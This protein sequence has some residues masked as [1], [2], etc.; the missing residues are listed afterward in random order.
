M[1]TMSNQQPK[2]QADEPPDTIWGAKAIGEEID[3]TEP[4]VYRLLAAGALQGA[5]RKVSHKTI[6]ASRSR[7]RSLPFLKVK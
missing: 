5:A 7:L 6:V 2:P 1:V 3:R 4:Q